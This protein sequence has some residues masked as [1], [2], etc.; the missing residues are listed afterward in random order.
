MI[1]ETVIIIW[2]KYVSS[3]LVIHYCIL[4]NYIWDVNIIKFDLKVEVWYFHIK[5]YEDFSDHSQC[6]H[7]QKNPYYKA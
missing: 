4:L 5:T 1:K 7:D 2:S 3:G 6:S